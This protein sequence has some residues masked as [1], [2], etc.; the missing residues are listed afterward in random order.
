MASLISTFSKFEFKIQKLNNSKRLPSLNNKYKTFW[1]GLRIRKYVV[2]SLL[3]LIKKSTQIKD[4][5]SK[6]RMQTKN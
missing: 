5:G 6:V 1:N 2:L 4:L 3:E